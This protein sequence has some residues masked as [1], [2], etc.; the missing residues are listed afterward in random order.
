MI[1]IS[2]DE[3]NDWD[4]GTFVDK[5]EAVRQTIKSELKSFKRDYFLDVTH[6]IDWLIYFRK[7]PD[8]QGLKR[9]ITTTI[10]NIEEVKEVKDFDM[11]LKDRHLS[12]YL[13]YKDIYTA[14]EQTLNVTI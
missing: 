10:L 7:H 9:E 12:I 11:Q 8:L 2:V 1:T 6:G 14:K 5:H 3:N 4:F 13:T